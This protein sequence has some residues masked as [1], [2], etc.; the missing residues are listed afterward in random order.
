MTTSELISYIKKQIEKNIPKD[1]IISKLVGAGW[2]REDIDEGFLSIDKY[3]EPIEGENIFEVEKEQPK[4]EFLRTEEQ[5][6]ATPII[7]TPKIEISTIKPPPT[8][9]LKVETPVVKN[10]TIDIAKPEKTKEQIPIVEI[11]KI[12]SPTAETPIEIP[13]IE[14]QKV[15]TPIRIPVKEVK[16]PEFLKNKVE[17][18]ELE[19][20]NLELPNKEGMI[21]MIKQKPVV[22][23]LGYVVGANVDNLEKIDNV[24]ITE[25]PQ[26]SS[27]IKDL[28]KI[29]MLSSYPKEMLAMGKREEEKIKSKKHKLFRISVIVLVVVVLAFGIWVFASGTINIKNLNIPFI[30][31]DPKVLI[32]NNSKV[33]ASLNSYKTETNIEIS[34]P[35]FAN[36]SAGLI[37]GEAV[38]SIDEDTFTINTLGV[39]NQTEQGLLS[40]NFV[41]IKSSI[42]QD[43]I[44]T[45]IKNNGTDLFITVPDLSQ[46]IQE[47]IPESSVVKINEQQFGLFPALFSPEK[48]T[49]LKKINIYR[50]LSSGM[51]SYLNK[52]TLTAYDNFIN[53]VEIT[54]KGQENIKGIDTYHYSINADRQLAKNLLSKISNDFILNLSEADNT[55]LAEILGSVTVNSLEVWVGKGDS[56]IYQYNVSLSI[57]LSKIIGFEDKS[58]GDNKVNIVWKTTY[59]DFNISNSIFVPEEST[60]ALDFVDNI[61]K[62]KVKNDVLSFKQVATSLF[63]SEKVYGTKSNSSGNCMNPTSGS[64]FS[65]LGHTKGAV[66]AVSS[67]SSLL[68]KTLGTTNG[69]GYCY[70][71]PKAW[72]FTVP[73]SD[74]YDPTLVP[75]GGYNNFFCVDSTDATATLTASPKGTI[76]SPKTTQT[77]PTIVN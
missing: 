66:T 67:I 14:T 5:K 45:D 8:I 61:K 30:K 32:L 22:N 65:P 23:S 59:Y 2:H 24:V 53:D 20:Q 34:S 47:K 4:Q 12:Y 42:L 35:S 37:T 75:V 48:E 69:N 18:T 77:A 36:I 70:S 3:R 63:N 38:S 49:F 54:E 56:N 26:N 50:L 9:S 7:E 58:I 25:N 74:N 43:Q 52:E 39:I 60:P 6:I 51:S 27:S 15:W 41:T 55:R 31:K 44:I 19:I 46:L 71:T 76:C 21:P 68:N 72:S 62:E 29:A 33:L 10:I 64:L 17:E 57:P 1:L 16:E 73:I 40:D 13:K 11:Q 28:P